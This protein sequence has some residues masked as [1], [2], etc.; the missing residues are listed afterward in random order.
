MFNKDPK[1]NIY[2][3]HLGHSMATME[4]ISW[5][6]RLTVTWIEEINDDNLNN[7][8]N[9][10]D[11]NHSKPIQEWYGWHY[12][13]VLRWKENVQFGPNECFTVV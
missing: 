3:F 5:N 12:H 6:A 9:Q 8:E 1:K 11:R 10:K 2:M 7:E 13:V 4:I